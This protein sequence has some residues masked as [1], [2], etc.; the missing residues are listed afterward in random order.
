[1]V[2]WDVYMRYAPEL[3]EVLNGVSERLDTSDLALLNL[4]AED[5]RAD[6]AELARLWLA[7]A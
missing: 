5:P 1:M 7:S 3:G 4:Q 2:R 6:L